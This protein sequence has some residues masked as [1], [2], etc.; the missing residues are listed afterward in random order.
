MNNKKGYLLLESVISLFVVLTISLSL[1]FFIYYCSKYKQSI[2][3][4]IELCEQGEEMHYQINKMIEDSNFIISIRDLNGK[5]TY[6]DVLS[7]TKISSL[8]CKYKNEYR[9]DKKDKELSYKRNHKLFINTLYSNGNSESG[10]YEIGD[11]VDFV[12]VK[13]NKNKVSIKLTLS[14]NKEKYET[15]FHSYIKN[16]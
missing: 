12:E 15:K 10:G 16:F 1:Y 4:K 14:K 11:Y 9:N 2:E 8:K 13:I 5:T 6:G 3:D 7:Y